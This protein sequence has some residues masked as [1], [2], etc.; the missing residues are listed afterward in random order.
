MCHSLLEPLWS[1]MMQYWVGWGATTI[2]THPPKPWI[3]IHSSLQNTN[4]HTE[5]QQ[6]WAYGDRK[7]KRTK[8]A[9]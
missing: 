7:Q 9:R 8:V 5:R 6:E 4:T 3:V 1:D 2:A